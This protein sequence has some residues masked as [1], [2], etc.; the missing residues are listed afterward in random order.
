PEIGSSIKYVRQ[1]Y[2]LYHFK[3]HLII[4]CMTSTVIDIVRVLGENMD[5]K[6]HL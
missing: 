4:Y 5:V 1:G 3:H 2:R 6:R